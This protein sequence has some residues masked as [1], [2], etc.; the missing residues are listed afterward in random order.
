MKWIRSIR[1]RFALWA[2]ALILVFLAA[3]GGFVYINLSVS[4]H[5]AIDDTLSFG[6]AQTA[7]S[8][9]V[10][11]GQILILEPITLD[12]SGSEAFTESGLTL[13]VLSNDGS[14]LQAAGPYRSYPA[15]VA[16]AGNQ[17]VFLTLPGSGERD[18]IRIYILPVLDNNQV[19]GWVQAMQSL[20]N[21]DDS[22]QRL[23]VTL[24][25]GGGMLSLLAG[26]AGY[27]L[28]ARTLAPI[29]NI[30]HTARRISTAD[31]SARLNLPDTGDEVSRL[32]ATFDE[33]LGRLE[34][35][36]KRERQF[37]ADA[38]HELRTPLAALQAILSVTRARERS[39]QEYQQALEDLSDE[40]D[41]MRGLVEDLLS[42]ARGENGFSLHLEPL[43]LALLLSDV[44]ESLRPLAGSRGLEFTCDLPPALPF[45]GDMDALIRL[46]VNL[47]DNA[48]KYTERGSVSLSA[49][50]EENTII[51]KV[52]DTGI[53]IPAEHLAH[54][55]ERFYRVETAR[56]SG[57]VGLGLA[58]ARQIAKA[59]GG[60]I[61]VESSPNAGTTFTVKLPLM[62]QSIV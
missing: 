60:N 2:T 42:L 34:T 8:L 7:A 33:M 3:F 50:Q 23:L 37:T 51:V 43:D 32:S 22:L 15:P 9:N 13:V 5:T 56:S 10:E 24:F 48:I 46:F 55:F 53:G 30:T 19:V 31:L 36:F 17:S 27:F 57:G 52:S 45:S 4:L 38:S 59:H 40:T 16:N 1:A 39:T 54:I 20:G 29:D 44:S 21:V 26:F 11:N 25:L 12:E 14:I 28:A 61:E 6:A 35:G 62:K 18:S 49:R 47:L 41:R 58:I